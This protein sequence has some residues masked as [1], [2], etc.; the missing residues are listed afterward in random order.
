MKSSIVE[1]IDSL[2]SDRNEGDNKV[3]LSNF[4]KPIY[5]GPNSIRGIEKVLLSSTTEKE[6]RISSE[7][8]IK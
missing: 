6:L 2:D 3:V 8:K 5:F 1:E 4:K 7:V